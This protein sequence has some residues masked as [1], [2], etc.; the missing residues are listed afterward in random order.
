MQHAITFTVDGGALLVDDVV[1]LN[2]ALTNVK[3]VALNAGLCTLNGATD[4]GG[5]ERLCLIKA[6]AV[7]QADHALTSEPLHQVVF[8]R[9]VEARRTWVA[10]AAGAT[11]EL[12]IDTARVVS[13]GANDTETASGEN[14]FTIGSAGALCLG[15]C[16]RVGRGIN[17]GRI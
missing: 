4:H 8:Q 13:L 15:E 11:T 3:V 6:K 10:L 7:H 2:D 5:L 14:D 12:V 1:K 16:L 9:E 17:L